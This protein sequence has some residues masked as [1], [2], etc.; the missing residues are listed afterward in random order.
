MAASW[1]SRSSA[2][3]SSNSLF[4]FAA[5]AWVSC[6]D[7]LT[8]SLW[9]CSSCSW[10]SSEDFVAMS[11]SRSPWASESVEL[12]CSRYWRCASRRP[13]ASVTRSWRLRI[14][15]SSSATRTPTACTLVSASSLAFTAACSISPIFCLVSSSS[16]SSRSHAATRCSSSVSFSSSLLCATLSAEERDWPSA[17]SACCIFSASSRCAML[18][19]SASCRAS[20]RS[21]LSR[22]AS[23]CSPALRSS[24]SARRSRRPCAWVRRDSCMR[25]CCAADSLWSSVSAVNLASR[26]RRCSLTSDSACVAASISARALRRTTTNSVSSAC[27]CSASFAARLVVVAARSRSSASRA[28]SCSEV[29]SRTFSDSSAD[30]C[31]SIFSVRAK[32]WLASSSKSRCPPRRPSS[33]AAC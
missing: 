31:S 21:F 8:A 12:S 7:A 3:R 14:S 19:R 24:A 26:R 4:R 22:S 23:C 20:S 17:S 13:S 33:V 27:A 11:A 5:S 1:A 29:S 28:S 10:F 18:A 32:L 30:T 25:V 9:H 16:F 2:I 15:P 6:S